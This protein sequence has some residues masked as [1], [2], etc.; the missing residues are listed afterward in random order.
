MNCSVDTILDTLQ[1][2][3]RAS[4]DPEVKRLCS[5]LSIVMDT[6]HA[7]VLAVQT[8]NRVLLARIEEVASG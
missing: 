5:E 1:K 6:Y 4:D 2:M 7:D 3:A 8:E